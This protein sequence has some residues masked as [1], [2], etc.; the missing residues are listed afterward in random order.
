MRN[1]IQPQYEVRD[2]PA[3]SFGRIARC[4]SVATPVLLVPA[5][6]SANEADVASREALD[7]SACRAQAANGFGDAGQLAT[8]S[9]GQG[10]AQL[11]EPR[12]REVLARP[13][14]L[15]LEAAARV[16]RSHRV[17]ELA[18]AV[19]LKLAGSLQG[20]VTPQAQGREPT[21]AEI[22][23][24]RAA[25]VFAP[26]D[27][28]LL[29]KT[30]GMRELVSDVAQVVAAVSRWLSGRWRQRQQAWAT[31]RALRDLDARTLRD[32]GLDRSELRSIAAEVGGAIEVTRVHAVHVERS[33]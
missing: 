22:T 4:T 5:R 29:Y 8:G 3:E 15:Q 31:Y 2:T 24:V 9:A 1:S 28:P 16:D 32:I 33:Y 21:G 13:T 10:S 23:P 27:S 11:H 19:W 18:M 20:V 12:F 7:A 17:A 25:I 26:G 6:G 14:A 30:S